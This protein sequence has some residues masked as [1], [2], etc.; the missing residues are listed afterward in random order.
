MTGSLLAALALACAARP[1]THAV[2]PTL[3]RGASHAPVAA[4]STDPAALWRAG[5]TYAVYAAKFSSRRREWET[6]DGW[7]SIPDSLVARTKALPAMVRILAVADESCSD[8]MNSIPYLARLAALA[9]TIDLRIVNSARGRSVMESYRNV[10]GNAVTPTVVVL[11]A[12]DRVVGCWVERPQRLIRWLRTPKD[13]LPADERFA[14][15]RAWYESDKGRAALA[16]WIP[17]LE[18]IARGENTCAAGA[19]PTLTVGSAMARRGERAY[20]AIAVPAGVDSGTS[21]A[22]SVIHGARPGPVVALVAGAHGTEYASIVALTKV[23]GAIDPKTLSGSVIV[24]PLLNVASF[25]QMTVHTNPVDGKGF[26]AN[27]PGDPAGTQT[28]RALALVAEQEV[29]QA[30]VIVDLHGG[31]LDEDLRPYSYWAR[32]GDPKSD[33]A[34]K[35]L[36]LAF[37]LDHIIILDLDISLPTGRRNLA[38]YALSLGKTAFIAEAG[39][40]GMSSPQDVGA[41]VDGCL[42]VMGTLRMIDRTVAPIANPVWIVSDARV[43]A[44][45]PGMFTALVAR[46]AYVTQ[47]M[48]VGTL[49]DYLGRPTGDVKAPISGV[50]TFIRSVPSVWKNATLVNVGTPAAEPLPYK[51]P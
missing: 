19:R 1:G 47:G 43:R 7:A 22:V 20:G 39:R 27:Y 4:D 24:A 16:E 17:M 31:D 48:K 21:I 23:I 34:S 13:S 44:D 49:T 10:D 36:A 50:V 35:A 26:N 25:E 41:L 40:A 33:K 3:P 28:Q 45:A 51:K 15:R 14:D 29:K 18:R 9:G 6:R 12:R 30:D 5:E 8:S 42:N 2:V 11:D 46:G 37:G 32:T 38:G